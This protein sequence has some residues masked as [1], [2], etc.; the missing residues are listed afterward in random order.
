MRSGL[1]SLG[2]VNIFEAMIF[3]SGCCPVYCG[4]FSNILGLT[5]NEVVGWHH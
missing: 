2:T 3:G 4:M 1:F 5:E